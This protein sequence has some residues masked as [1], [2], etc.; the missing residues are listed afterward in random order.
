VG[1]GEEKEKRGAA[2]LGLSYS[3]PAKISKMIRNNEQ[4]KDICMCVCV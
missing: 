4:I 1:K 2:P 3:N